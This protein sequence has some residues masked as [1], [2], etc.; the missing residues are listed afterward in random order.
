MV[1]RF[2]EARLELMIPQIFH[3]WLLG[4]IMVS[5][6]GSWH[7]VSPC[8]P[9]RYTLPRPWEDFNTRVKVV[10]NTAKLCQQALVSLSSDS[11]FLGPR[12]STESSEDTAQQGKCLVHER[13]EW[14]TYL[15][16]AHV[17]R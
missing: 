7:P 1:G 15:A 16:S 12:V 14:A 8:L 17:K 3:R 13:E 5:K 10:D 6:P 9:S 2:Q 4:T 11:F